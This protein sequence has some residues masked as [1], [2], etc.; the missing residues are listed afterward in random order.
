MRQRADLNTEKNPTARRKDLS[1]C[2]RLSAAV[3]SHR[4]RI[5]SERRLGT[6]Q[7]LIM[8]TNPTLNGNIAT[9]SLT[10]VVDV[11]K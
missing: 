6:K 4:E 10:G 1:S 3:E 8:L 9:R 5:K 11:A 2:V 7:I